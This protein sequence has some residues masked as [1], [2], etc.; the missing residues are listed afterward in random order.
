[1]PTTSSSASTSSLLAVD[2]EEVETRKQQL[3]KIANNSWGANLWS[4]A[5]SSQQLGI[6]LKQLD[7]KC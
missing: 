6:T 2:T 1:M 7:N 4:Y 3:I 5:V